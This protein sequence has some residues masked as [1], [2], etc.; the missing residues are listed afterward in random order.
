MPVRRYALS[1]SILTAL[2]VALV[3]AFGAVQLA[4]YSLD[5]SAAAPG[6]LPTRVPFEFGLRVYRMLD[7]I[8]PAAFVESSLATAELARGDADA[9]ERYALRLAASPARDELLARVAAARGQD[10]LAAEYLLAAPDPAAI[11]ARADEIAR[12]DPSAAYALEGLLALRLE[13]SRTHPDAVAQAYWRMGLFANRTAW[14]QVPGSARQHEWLD[15]GLSA[16]ERAVG[17]APLSERY[18]VAA[19]NQA[20]LL[21]DRERARDLFAR[22][23][24]IDPASADAIAGLGV[25]AWESGDA[26][27][28]SRYLARARSIDPQSLMVRA[29][30]RDIANRQG[31][32]R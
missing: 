30:E 7:R 14:R 16:F 3:A 1:R 28:S 11:E 15:R 21:N 2:L 4:S 20:N 23:V 19:A 9:A 6:T 12:R 24:A 32:S 26:A 5:S 13:R 27:A 22:A 8:A 29:L 18:A 10:A 17:V 31:P 25:V